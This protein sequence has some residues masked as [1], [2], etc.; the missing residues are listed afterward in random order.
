MQEL[1]LEPEPLLFELQVV[2]NYLEAVGIHQLVV[3]NLVEQV[4]LGLE[5]VD[6]LVEQQ[7]VGIHLQQAVDNHQQVVDN[8]LQVVGIRRLELVDNLHQHCFEYCLSYGT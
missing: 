8:Y 7:V 3:D 4:V 5:A 1:E 2:G 6:K